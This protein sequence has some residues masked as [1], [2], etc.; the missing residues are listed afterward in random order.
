[1]AY[2]MVMELSMS[3]RKAVTVKKAVAYRRADRRTKSRI[4]DELVELTGWHRDHCRAAI[5][6]TYAGQTKTIKAPRKPR[7]VVYGPEIHAA[8]VIVWQLL[9]YPAGKRLAAMLPFVVPLL[10]RDG[11]LQLDA[12]SVKLLVG[13]SAA[14][15]DRALQP[16][17]AKW[18]A[19]GRSHTKPGTLLKSQI[20]VRTWADW[21][22]D[23]PGF[24]EIDLVG[25]EGGK[26]AES[27]VSRSQLLT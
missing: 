9:R 22:D 4:L 5:R 7:P 25:H 21:D 6:S 19:R 27:S 20:P 15:I 11:E 13:M 17:R 18:G 24:I 26:A 2:A 23:R 10:V 3:Q 16:E 14:T 1:M 8:L 12:V